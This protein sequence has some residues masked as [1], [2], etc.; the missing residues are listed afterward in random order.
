M[1]TVISVIIGLFL[2]KFYWTFSAETIDAPTWLMFA[3]SFFSF[4]L[5]LCSVISLYKTARSKKNLRIALN[6]VLSTLIV[7]AFLTSGVSW[8]NSAIFNSL[9]SGRG[10]INQSEI[11]NPIICGHARDVHGDLLKISTNFHK[12]KDDL[13]YS[14][15]LCPSIIYKTDQV[16]IDKGLVDAIEKNRQKRNS[17]SMN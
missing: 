10:F 2:S 8:L 16:I 4:V 7:S 15:V 17:D 12:K 13:T 5:I 1:L 11:K 6:F 3:S 9:H 14:T